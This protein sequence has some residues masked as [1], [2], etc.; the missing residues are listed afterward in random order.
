MRKDL[1]FD[2]LKAIA[3]GTLFGLILALA[4]PAKAQADVMDTTYYDP[5]YI[6]G[7][8]S[9]GTMHAG[10]FQAATNAYA[11]G[12]LL[13]VCWEGCAVVVVDDTCGGCGLDLGI[14]A[15]EAIGMVEAGRVPAEVTVL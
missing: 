7:I 12:T 3:I 10:G 13:E 1:V 6:G 15:A 5:S 14:A 8:T 2:W 11:P 9:S 4:W